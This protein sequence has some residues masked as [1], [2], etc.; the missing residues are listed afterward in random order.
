MQRRGGSVLSDHQGPVQ[1]ALAPG[2]GHGA[3]LAQAVWPKLASSRLQHHQ[4]ASEA[5]FGDDRDEADD[6][7]GIASAG[8]QYR[9]QD[10]GR[11]RME[12]EKAWGRLPSPMAQG[13][14]W[15]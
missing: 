11:R 14:S 6:H 9:H 12:D 8:R 4:P 3:E 13:P 2:D 1:S 5:S 10:A 7:D 15:H